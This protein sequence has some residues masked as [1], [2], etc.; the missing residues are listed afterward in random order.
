M[1]LFYADRITS[2]RAFFD[3]DESRHIAKTF[4]KRVG[5]QLQFTEGKGFRYTG[6]IVTIS[7]KAIEADLQDKVAIEKAWHGRLHMALAPTKNFNRIEWIVERMVELG[8]DE[9]TPIITER[10]ERRTWKANRLDRLIK[11]A[12]KQS[13]K[14]ELPVVH[15]PVDFGEFCRNLDDRTDHYFGHC[16][17]GEKSALT[18]IELQGKSVCFAVGPEGDFSPEEISMA[19]DHGFQAVTLG[20]QRLRTETAAMKMAVAFHIYNDWE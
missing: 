9:L 13:L 3:I 7:K 12:A 11:A 20:Q 6:T 2:D 1:E 14:C 15:E 17:E 8:L 10:S 4:R 5:D 18:D 16:E 19:Y